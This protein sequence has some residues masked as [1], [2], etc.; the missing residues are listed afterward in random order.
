[1]MIMFGCI[2]TVVPKWAKDGRKTVFFLA[3]L[4]LRESDTIERL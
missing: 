2:T 1:M 4:K 3:R